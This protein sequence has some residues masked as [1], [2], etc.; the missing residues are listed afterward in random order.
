MNSVIQNV[1]ANPSAYVLG[2]LQH[3]LLAGIIKSDYYFIY[4]I[5]KYSICIVQISS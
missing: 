1:A 5:Y 2:F 4:F 3:V